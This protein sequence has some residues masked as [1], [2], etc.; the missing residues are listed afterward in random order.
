M[1]QQLSAILQRQS[2]QAFS[3]T[4]EEFMRFIF[5]NREEYQLIFYEFQ[6]FL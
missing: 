6:D 1:G 4:V 2:H 3:Y 5:A